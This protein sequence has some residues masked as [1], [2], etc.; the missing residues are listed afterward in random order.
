MNISKCSSGRNIWSLDH[1]LSSNTNGFVGP[2]R[3]RGVE[4]IDLIVTTQIICE[5][6]LIRYV[7]IT[8]PSLALLWLEI[9]EEDLQFERPRCNASCRLEF[10]CDP[11]MHT[12]QVRVGI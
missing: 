12:A 8:D 5:A 11:R 2:S 6:R 10:G 7:D 3:K 1:D 9:R 4:K